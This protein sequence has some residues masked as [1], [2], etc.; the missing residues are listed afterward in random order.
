MHLSQRFYTLLGVLALAAIVYLPSS[1]LLM[2]VPA[3]DGGVFAYIGSRMVEGVVPYRDA[4]DHKP[5][6]TYLLALLGSLLTRGSLWGPWLMAVLSLTAAGLLVLWLLTSCFERP[7]ARAGLVLWLLGMAFYSEGDPLLTEPAALPF[8]LA[9]Y[10]M[11]LLVIR[12]RRDGVWGCWLLLGFCTA[13]CLLLKPPLAST[14]L[15]ATATALSVLLRPQPRWGALSRAAALFLGGLLL[16]VGVAVAYLVSRGAF[17][18]FLDQV[19]IY[20]GVYAQASWATR[21]EVLLSGVWQLHW[22]SVLA[23]GAWLVAIWFLV[24][25]RV[26]AQPARGVLLI[27]VIDFPLTLLLALT[28]GRPYIH[29]FTG[30]L[31]PQIV[32][33]CWALR[34]LFIALRDRRPRERLL[35]ALCLAALTSIDP[36]AIWYVQISVRSPETETRLAALDYLSEELAPARSVLLWGAE[37]SLYAASGRAAPSR[38]LYL[39][40]LLTPGYPSLPALEMLRADLALAPPDIIIDTAMTNPLIPPL[41]AEARAAWLAQQPAHSIDDAVLELCEDLGERYA[42]VGRLGAGWVVYMR[43]GLA[44]A[45]QP[46]GL[47]LP[48]LVPRAALLPREE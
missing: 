37:T 22:L 4:W 19:L 2:P 40:P 26:A 38:I 46:A 39:Y 16:P 43:R 42:P 17:W 24:V 15:I 14:P 23:L 32:L 28:S 25:R 47:M 41:G 13:Y 33:L 35:V 48:A 1:P 3:R 12:R 5:P 6:A 10:A 20:N 9:A 44:G 29:Y 18:Q 45:D 34:G 7:L 36:L 21:L 31:W 8:Q 30:L 27:A 11:A